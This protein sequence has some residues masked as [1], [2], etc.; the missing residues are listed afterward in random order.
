MKLFIKSEN[1]L[2]KVKILPCL[3]QQNIFL[4]ISLTFFKKAF[5]QVFQVFPG[6]S[7]PCTSVCVKQKWKNKLISTAAPHLLH[8]CLNAA[9]L[10]FGHVANYLYKFWNGAN[11]GI[12]IPTTKKVTVLFFKRTNNSLFSPRARY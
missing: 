4:W 7:D 8:F 2:Q 12:L 1:K 9:F 3:C 11:I 10:I 5:F 6:L